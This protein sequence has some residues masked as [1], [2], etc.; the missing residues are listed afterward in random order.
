MREHLMDVYIWTRAAIQ[1]STEPKVQE[2]LDVFIRGVLQEL[3]E[4]EWLHAAQLM[5]GRLP[6][7]EK[8]KANFITFTPP[9]GA[10]L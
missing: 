8:V 5:D 3:T 6:K 4:E 7:G 9:A 10:Q 1:K 2:Y